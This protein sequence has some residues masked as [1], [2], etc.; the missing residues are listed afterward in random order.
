MMIII[1]ANLTSMF[2]QDQSRMAASP[3]HKVNKQP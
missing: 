3:Q 2:F 1:I